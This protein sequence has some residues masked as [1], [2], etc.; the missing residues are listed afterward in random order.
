MLIPSKPQR[1]KPDPF[2]VLLLFV[3][4]GMCVTL[5][6]QVMLYSGA[7]DYPIAIQ[8]PVPAPAAVGG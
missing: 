3:S 5:T 8:T 6:Y 1:R 2:M 7:S 4:I